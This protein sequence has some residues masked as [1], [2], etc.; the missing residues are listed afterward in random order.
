MIG[1]DLVD[2]KTAQSESNWERRGFLNKLFCPTE[3]DAIL[4]AKDSFLA[5]WVYWT[6]KEAAYKI[7]SRLTGVRKFAPSSIVCTVVDDNRYGTVFHE[8]LQYFTETTINKDY[9]H[10]S[11]A[12][13]LDKL[14]DI[15]TKIIFHEGTM[16][17]YRDTHPA[18][19]SHHGN[20]LAL[21]Y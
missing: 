21:V 10:T 20:Y 16:P 17:A 6:M 12:M 5:V 14:A 19:V 4:A 9:V 2:L 11:A 15:H 13:Q 18:C 1:N 8:G 3:Q 7:H